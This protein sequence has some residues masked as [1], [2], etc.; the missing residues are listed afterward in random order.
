MG[1][2]RARVHRL[3]PGLGAD[4]GR[5]RPPGGD[6]GGARAARARLDVL[7]EQRARHPPRRGDLEGDAVRGEGAL[8][9]L[10]DRGHALRH[11]AGARRPA[12]RPDPQVR[13]RL[14]RHARL[15]DDEH[16][17][18]GAGRVPRGGGGLGG[19]PAGDRVHHAGGPVQR[20][21]GDRG[22]RRPPP[23]RAGRRDR[24]A[25][26]ARAP[27]PARVPRRPARAD[28]P[29]RHPAHLRRGGDL[30]PVRLRRRPGVLRHHARSLRARQGGGRRLPADGGRRPGGAHG[31]LRPVPRGPGGVHPADR[32][33]ERQPDRDRGRAR[34]RADPEASR[35]LRADARPR[36]GAEAGAPAICDAAGI[37]A[38]VVGEGVLF[39]IYFTDE[40][41]TD[42]RST[43]RA[44]RG[45]ARPLRPRSSGSAGSS[46]APRSSTSPSSTTR[47][48]WRRRSRRSSRQSPTCPTDPARRG[49]RPRAR[50][51]S[52]TG[53]PRASGRRS[54]ARRR[55]PR[56]PCGRAPPP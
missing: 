49:G 56:A 55:A 1:R 26:P 23:R 8:L 38:R 6:G 53:R 7:R 16:E 3:P 40:E 14:S 50:P 42:Y 27:A 5:A 41:I 12:P 17:P 10:G 35:D 2:E 32:H 29:A 9:Q 24:R 22:D 52:R 44:D 25:L 47:P 15:R 4:A 30:V 39:E 48:T 21:R 31:A 54:R 51:R 45:A 13:G 28:R 46:A 11:A 33:A 34:H 19:D 43:L 18:P 37:P 36:P 20:P